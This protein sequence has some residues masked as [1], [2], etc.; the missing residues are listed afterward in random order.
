LAVD[1]L[2]GDLYAGNNWGLFKLST[3]ESSDWVPTSIGETIV[4]TIAIA[5]TDPPTIY[6]TALGA[7]SPLR[8]LRYR[9]LFRSPDAGKS[10]GIG[11]LN[12]INSVLID[13]SHPNTAYAGASPEYVWYATGVYKTEDGGGHWA[14]STGD[15]SCEVLATSLADPAIL[16]AGNYGGIFK[17]ID[18]GATWSTVHTG[19]YIYAIAVDPT[20]PSIVYAGSATG[21]F[22]SVHGVLKTTDAGATWSF[23]PLSGY[24]FGPLVV[25][26]L[27]R[28][29]FIGTDDGVLRSDDE[30]QHWTSFSDGLTG[31]PVS[32]LALGPRSTLYAGT[33]DGVFAISI[34]S[35]ATPQR[36]PARIVDSR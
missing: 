35:R 29:I 19:D 17:S 32:S 15:F 33:Q 23:L 24:T 30:G 28:V 8:G 2:S 7:E 31:L 4:Y 36:P 3:G 5:P 16:Y 11:V 20:S 14:P 9:T 27:S 34:L 12:S 1:P 10:W 26:P 25:D 22:P 21:T 6:V 13:P 18:A